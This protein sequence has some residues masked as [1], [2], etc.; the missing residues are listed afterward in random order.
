MVGLSTSHNTLRP[1]PSYEPYDKWRLRSTHKGYAR[2]EDYQL[3]VFGDP[4]RPP[5]Y[6]NVAARP[7]DT[8]QRYINRRF[9]SHPLIPI[10]I[11]DFYQPVL[12]P[13]FL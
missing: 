10:A 13:I 2:L 1:D 8:T 4:V 9:I 11:Q 6:K 3:R 5:Y 7:A 12:P